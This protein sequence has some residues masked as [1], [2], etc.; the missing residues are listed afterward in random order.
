MDYFN[1]LYAQMPTSG[2]GIAFIQ[3]F[4][5][6]F[7]KHCL[8]IIK[9]EKVLVTFKESIVGFPSKEINRFFPVLRISKNS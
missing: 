8:G 3:H 5:H 7:L 6:K 9:T 1:N 2:W 4:N